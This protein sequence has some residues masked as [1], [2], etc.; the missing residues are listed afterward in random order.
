MEGQSC[1]QFFA[2]GTWK[3]YFQVMQQAQAAQEADSI[4]KLSKAALDRRLEDIEEA[5]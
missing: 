4:I 2:V 3:R 5:R 1:Q